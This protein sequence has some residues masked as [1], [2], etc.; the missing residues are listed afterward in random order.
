MKKMLILLL[1]LG[2]MV[3][4][5]LAEG[6]PP[7]EASPVP[8]TQVPATKVPA[9]E[10][11][12]TKVPAT[13]APATKVPA[14]EAPATKVPATEAPAT[15][16]PATEAP[17][18]EAPATEAPA[19]E[20]PATEAPATEAPATEAPATEAPATEV[21]ATEA[22]ATEAPATEVPTTEVPATATPEITPEPSATPIP[23]LEGYLLDEDGAKLKGGSL[24]ELL[25]EPGKLRICVSTRQM[26][27]LE[28]F[29]LQRLQQISFEPDVYMVGKNHRV[30]LSSS[31]SIRDEFTSE[32]IAAFTP[33]SVGDLYIWLREEL[34]EPSATP[35]PGPGMKL[36]VSAEN[37]VE[38]TWSCLQPLFTLE[39]ITEED[40]DSNY[41][42]IILNERIAMLS[43]N[44]YQPQEEGVYDVRFAIMDPMG[45]IADRSEPYKLKLDFTPPALTVEVSME[46]DRTMTL[47]FSDALSGLDAFS[48]D[49]GENWAPIEQGMDSYTYT[50]PK[51]QSFAPGMILVRDLAGNISAN[52]EEVKLTKLPS[53]SGGGGGGGSSTPKKEH[54]SG[55]GDDAKYNSYELELPEGEVSE[56]TL[57]GEYVDL[58]LNV[59]AAGEV[60]PNG[61]FTAGLIHWTRENET[62]AMDE[63]T[64]VEPAKDTLLLKAVVEEDVQQEGEYT[65]VWK[66]NGAVLRKLYNSDIHYLLLDVNGTM[67]SLPT[68]GFSAGTRYAELKMHGVSTAEFEYEIRMR[69]CEKASQV[70]QGPA[71]SRASDC[72]PQIW[73]QVAGERFEMKDRISTPEMYPL[74]VYCA[75]EDLPDYPY[76]KY[77]AFTET[78]G[79]QEE[80]L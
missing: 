4:L 14:T 33:E 69:V 3:P 55:D 2:I 41:A 47:H 77:P 76:G 79:T 80:G 21:P 1:I 29:P 42:V 27:K 71:Y 18:T 16:V 53:F 58:K 6:M 56:L 68:E 28:D 44:V 25:M 12:A 64:T 62:L 50:A 23:Q 72:V 75:G 49:G 43:E 67:L 5:A 38:D 45:D 61:R 54:A 52:A 31:D 59:E 65:C 74:N 35:E 48:L 46:K 7:T 73:A 78:I 22:P 66:V 19:T 40:Q 36:T 57:G 15:K 11:P 63:T 13:E 30:V 24:A 26:I 32:A 9:T 20:A 70:Q 37:Y 34:P 8:A 39:G 60:E 17:A 51:K 10:V